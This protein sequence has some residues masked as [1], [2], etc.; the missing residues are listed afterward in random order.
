MTAEKAGN[1]NKAGARLGDE[2]GVACAPA[3]CKVHCGRS[4]LRLR[5]QCVIVTLVPHYIDLEFRT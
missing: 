3:V 1:I 2:E 5:L 4:F